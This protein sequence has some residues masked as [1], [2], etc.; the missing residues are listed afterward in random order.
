MKLL[1]LITYIALILCLSVEISTNRYRKALLK[2]LLPKVKLEL[3][4]TV[5]TGCAQEKTVLKDT[6]LHFT[7]PQDKSRKCMRCSIQTHKQNACKKG[8]FRLV[9]SGAHPCLYQKDFDKIYKVAPK[10]KPAP[11]NP[12]P[13]DPKV[14]QIEK[15]S[16][17][18]FAHLPAEHDIVFFLIDA[19]GSM[20][21]DSQICEN[22][23]TNKEWQDYLAA[24]K[25]VSKMHVVKEVLKKKIRSL[26]DKQKFF[27]WE[28]NGKKTF[29]NF[30]GSKTKDDAHM[31]I[32]KIEANNVFYYRDAFEELLPR[33][34][35]LGDNA[36]T[37]VSLLTDGGITNENPAESA[38]LKTILAKGVKKWEMFLY[39]EGGCSDPLI[40]A[41]EE[42]VMNALKTAVGLYVCR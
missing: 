15:A 31:F 29:D 10:P 16:K 3:D 17:E 38:T 24:G 8:C 2:N 37:L 6:K 1:K 18:M 9:D 11:A 32:D 25:Y 5:C 30:E 33:I 14:D 13:A 39:S 22:T 12:K 7:C 34:E 42:K 35:K 36:H 26:P 21:S 23:L 4:H 19:S 20:T 28:S 40:T 27:I 41:E